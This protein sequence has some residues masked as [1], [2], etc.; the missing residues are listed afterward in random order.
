MGTGEQLV[1]VLVICFQSIDGLR[2]NSARSCNLCI[3][4]QAT[5]KP[6]ITC[7]TMECYYVWPNCEP[8]T[9]PRNPTEGRLCDLL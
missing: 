1:N 3:C 5:N 4:V 7:P 8:L 2:R 9:V 6:A